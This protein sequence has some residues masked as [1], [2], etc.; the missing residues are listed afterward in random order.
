MLPI[1]LQDPPRV[2]N[3]GLAGF[4]ADLRA[5]GVAVVEV[6]W[7]PPAGGNVRL[8]ALLAQLEDEPEPIP[9]TTPN[10]RSTR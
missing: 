10:D 4:A 2:V 3:I 1:L 8:A 9:Q 5:Q 6:D 7:R